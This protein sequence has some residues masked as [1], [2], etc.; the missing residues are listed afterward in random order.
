MTLVWLVARP[1]LSRLVTEGLLILAFLLLEVLI[2]RGLEILLD[3]NLLF[4]KRWLKIP[5]SLR[6][7]LTTSSLHFTNI[8]ILWVFKKLKQGY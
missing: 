3:K 4:R 6:L 7:L 5:M 1:L 8:L 2:S